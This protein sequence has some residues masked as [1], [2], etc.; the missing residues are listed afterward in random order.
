MPSIYRVLG[1][2]VAGVG[3]TA[4]LYFALAYE[5]VPS[6]WRFVERRH[7]AFDETGSRSFTAAGI[8]GDPFNLAFVGSEDELQRL[9]AAVNWAPADA[10]TFKSSLR[11]TIAS[12]SHRSYADAP[13]SNLYVNGKK[14]DLAFEQAAAGDPRQRHHVRFWK[15]TQL[16]LLD[17]PLWIGAATFDTS[18]G[19]SHTTGQVTHH[20]DP[21]IDA[22]RDKLV[23]DAAQIDGVRIRWVDAFQEAREGRNGSGDRFFTDG[24]LAQFDFAP[25]PF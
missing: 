12:V 25:A 13:V 10:I 2:L 24:R 15:M 3:M 6:V 4:A 8:P 9:M 7:P 11:I 17:R 18:V 23:A 20:I 5:F 1:L 16:D 21:N 19:L 22:E 14:Q